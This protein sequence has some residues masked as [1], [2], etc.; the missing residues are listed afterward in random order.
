IPTNNVSV[1]GWSNGTEAALKYTFLS[2]ASNP[3]QTLQNTVL[4]AAKPG[5]GQSTQTNG[6]MAQCVNAAFDVLEQPS[7]SPA[8]RDKLQEN[9]YRLLYPFQGQQPYNGPSSGCTVDI[10]TSTD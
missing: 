3:S 6:N 4:I 10:T 2:P 5:G 9:N 8:L 1:I 7:T